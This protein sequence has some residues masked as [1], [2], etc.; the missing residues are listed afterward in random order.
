MKKQKTIAICLTDE[1]IVFID[2]MA[3][4]REISRSM[5]IRD[6]I[7]YEMDIFKADPDELHEVSW[8]EG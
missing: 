2:E 3:S 7:K 1:Q 5:Y 4:A 6:L 8:T